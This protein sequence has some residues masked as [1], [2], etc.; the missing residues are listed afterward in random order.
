M[1]AMLELIL[2]I[3]TTSVHVVHVSTVVEI[4]VVIV[5]SHTHVVHSSVTSE[6]TST[7]SEIVLLHSSS[8][9]VHVFVVIVIA[10]LPLN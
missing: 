3:K 8:V 9:T 4:I 2:V 5:P 7:T 1:H 6:T 10:V